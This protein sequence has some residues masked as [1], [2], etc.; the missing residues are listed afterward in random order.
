MDGVPMSHGSSFH[1]LIP[2]LSASLPLMPMR[3]SAWIMYNYEIFKT[4]FDAN[5]S[6]EGLYFTQTLFPSALIS[7]SSTQCSSE[8]SGSTGEVYFCRG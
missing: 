3:W 2:L 7:L 6:Q 4:F 8:K 1:S 5:S